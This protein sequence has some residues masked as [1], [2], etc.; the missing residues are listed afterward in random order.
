MTPPARR[1]QSRG[2][3]R[4]VCEEQEP[5]P[6]PPVG[7]KVGVPHPEEAQSERG[8]TRGRRGVGAWHMHRGG[9][10]SSCLTKRAASLMSGQ[11]LGVWMGLFVLPR[12]GRCPPDSSGGTGWQQ[13]GSSILPPHRQRR[14]LSKIRHD[15]SEVHAKFRWSIQK[16]RAVMFARSLG[17]Q[18]PASALSL[19]SP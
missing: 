19:P 2:R 7:F 5:P 18:T 14:N 17:P 9:H 6:F 16:K 8:V 12:R 10:L 11:R 13:S 15:G 1:D 4:P 3:L